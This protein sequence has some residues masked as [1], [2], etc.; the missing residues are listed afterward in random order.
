MQCELQIRPTE[1]DAFRYRHPD[2]D[3]ARNTTLTTSIQH[4]VYAK[5]DGDSGVVESDPAPAAPLAAA[6]EIHFFV[7]PHIRF[8]FQ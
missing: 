6:P 8:T 5:L 7:A 2:V 4:V 3:S 1:N